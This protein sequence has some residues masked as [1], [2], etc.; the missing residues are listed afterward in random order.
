VRVALVCSAHGLGHVAR[1]LALG[2]ALVEEGADVTVVTAAPAA[3]VADTL[4]EAAVLP[5][6][7]DVGIAQRDSLH[8]DLAETRRRLDTVASEAAIDRLADA[9]RDFDR[10]VADTAPTALEAARR[11][12]VSVVAVGNFD[13]AWTYEAYP[14]LADWATR[15]RAWQAPHT[16]LSLSPGPGLTGFAVTEEFG[17]LG[18]SAP[19]AGLPPCSVLVSFGGFG[20]DAM[21]ALLP[22]IPG[23][24][25]VAAAPTSLP[26]RPD[27]RVVS[28]VPYPALVAGADAVFTKPGYGILVEAMLSGARLVWVDRGAFPEAAHLARAMAARRDRRVPVGPS[29]PPAFRAALAA[30]VRA[31]LADPRPEVPVGSCAGAL[32]RRVLAPLPEATPPPPR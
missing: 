27:C 15:F 28:G 25:W 16:G 26:A 3:F 23:V 29:D 4:P 5:W 10:V 2:R 6:V 1:Q 18:R 7:V 31:R 9:L 8:E 22:E 13:W 17:P 11:A 32:A 30:A 12:G 14:E 21:D 24:T 19:P 20:L